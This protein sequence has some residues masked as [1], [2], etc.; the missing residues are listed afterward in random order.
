[1][2]GYK[3]FLGPSP[4]GVCCEIREQQMSNGLFV[5]DTALLPHRFRQRGAPREL[6]SGQRNNGWV[7][8]D[9]NC[10]TLE[11][12]VCGTIAGGAAE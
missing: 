1:M 8:T 7:F 2:D 6:A 9:E 5:Y 10:A 11:R 3:C 12:Q 4:L